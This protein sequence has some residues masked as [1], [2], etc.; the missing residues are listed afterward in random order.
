R[1]GLER[2]GFGVRPASID[3]ASLT[4]RNPTAYLAY[5]RGLEQLYRSNWL[6]ADQAFRA[7][8]AGDSTFAL[9]WYYAAVATW[10]QADL[11]GAK[12]EVEGA[13]RLGDRLSGRDREGIKAL[14]SLIT[15]DY[16]DAGRQYRALL[17]RYPD[18]K[19]FLYGLGEAL[20]HG[21][22][23]R[24]GA[25]QALTKATEI[26]PSF[27]VAY[28]HIFDIYVDREDLGAAFTT[29][30]RLV[31]AD[32]DNAS[33]YQMRAAVLFMR[34]ENDAALATCRDALARDTNSVLAM[35][36]LGGAYG[37]LGDFDSLRVEI[38]TLS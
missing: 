9:A 18:D 19:E 8:I 4:T 6:E 21:G 29:A 5:V 35:L 33:A 10:W 26:D 15:K 3:V 22:D 38:A 1:D 14:G 28:A 34:G 37:I 7:A 31:K 23:D 13:L 17:R 32:P 36:M 12:K 24:D 11:D 20:Y 25:L 2:A 27:G 30:D 16:S